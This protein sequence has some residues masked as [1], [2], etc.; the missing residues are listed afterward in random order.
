MDWPKGNSADRATDNP[1]LR[2]PKDGTL[3]H[4]SVHQDDNLSL[5]SSIPVPKLTS[6]EIK[7]IAHSLATRTPHGPPCANSVALFPYLIE[8]D[9]TMEFPFSTEFNKTLFQNN[10][11]LSRSVQTQVQSWRQLA[12]VYWRSLETF[13]TLQQRGYLLNSM[14]WCLNPISYLWSGHTYTKTI[15][16]PNLIQ[17]A[18]RFHAEPC[19]TSTS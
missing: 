1:P 7:A 10:H 2:L 16:L 15:S 14:Q 8:L 18:E 12:S 6:E 3:T 19:S 17:Q 5:P 13:R 9:K 4:N 11:G